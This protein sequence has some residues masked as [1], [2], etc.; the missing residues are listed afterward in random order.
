[1]DPISIT[2]LVGGTWTIL[3][4]FL[5]KVGGKLLEK[6]GEALPD[7]AGKVWDFVKEKMESK[8]E[9]QSL[10]ADLEKT[11][12]DQTVQGAFQYQLKKLLENDEDF[13]RRLEAMVGQAHQVTTTTATLTGNGA[14]AQG[15]GAKA[16]GA[17]GVMIGGGVSG[18]SVITGDGNAPPAEET[19]SEPEK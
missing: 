11:P 2:A 18:G 9:T 13:A 7:I 5:N 14:I 4:P 12:A 17:G 1:M 15:S 19:K 8:P 16:V 10:P 6:S 3:A